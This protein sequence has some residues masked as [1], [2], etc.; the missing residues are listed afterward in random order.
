MFFTLIVCSLYTGMLQKAVLRLFN[1]VSAPPFM[2][3]Q[4]LLQQRMCQSR[5]AFADQPLRVFSETLLSSFR[6][7][8]DSE[9][10]YHWTAIKLQSE[11]FIYICPIHLSLAYRD[12]LIQWSTVFA[13]GPSSD[14]RPDADIENETPELSESPRRGTIWCSLLFSLS[15]RTCRTSGSIKIPALFQVSNS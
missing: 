15:Y 2:G 13:S 10:P 4:C 6:R 7:D 1:C 3:F 12:F 9:I 8:I 11:N 14:H 5:Q